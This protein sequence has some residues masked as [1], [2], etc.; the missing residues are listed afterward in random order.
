MNASTRLLTMVSNEY[1][2][3]HTV[4]RV[5]GDN[6][7]NNARNANTDNSDNNAHNVHNANTANNVHSDNSEH[8][9]YNASTARNANNVNM[10]V[11]SVHPCTRQQREQC[12]A[13]ERRVEI[14]WTRRDDYVLEFLTSV[15][16]ASESMMVIAASLDP[17]RMR[18]HH[19]RFTHY[20]LT[21]VAQC[22]HY[23]S[24][25]RI[26]A[27]TTTGAALTSKPWLPT[28]VF[29]G[30]QQLPSMVD[31]LTHASLA[32]CFYRVQHG[33]HCDDILHMDEV[34]GV[35]AWIELC[36]NL[37]SNTARIITRTEINRAVRVAAHNGVD[38]RNEYGTRVQ[39]WLLDPASPSPETDWSNPARSTSM[40]RMWDNWLLSMR[41]MSV[42]A[43][44]ARNNDGHPITRSNN[45]RVIQGHTPSLVIVQPRSTNNEPRSIAVEL[46]VPTTRQSSPAG[47]INATVAEYSTNEG[48]QRYGEVFWLVDSPQLAAMV[49]N[50]ATMFHAHDYIH[51]VPVSI[52]SARSGE[53]AMY[54]TRGAYDEQ[55]TSIINDG[56]LRIN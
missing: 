9:V 23:T 20:E 16:F 33:A 21:G 22:E 37:A 4:N 31:M 12:H 35:G 44:D 26:W 14:G 51:I 38:L 3:A 27:A 30:E 50:A 11:H 28:T 53:P 18:E 36:D 19:Q 48:T 40:W 47:Y 5:H 32:S 7:D 56:T 2:S 29:P 46:T 55:H 8:N 24:M 15:G 45:D 10:S 25:P 6:T 43:V 41:T 34:H 13:R 42:H 52:T 54:I 39:Q 1:T 49:C 17:R